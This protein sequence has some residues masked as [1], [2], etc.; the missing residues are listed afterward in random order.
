[1]Y[2]LVSWERLT[3]KVGPVT[4]APMLPFLSVALARKAYVEPNVKETSTDVAVALGSVTK[5][6]VPP[7][8]ERW[9]WY[10]LIP[11]PAS[12]PVQATRPRSVVEVI[13]TMGVPDTIGRID[14]CGVVTVGAVA[15]LAIVRRTVAVS[16]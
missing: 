16:V 1:M 8:T 2:A 4:Q 13:V 11:T 6:K 7:L 5:A 9:S 15:S 14:S 3:A 12:V 10:E